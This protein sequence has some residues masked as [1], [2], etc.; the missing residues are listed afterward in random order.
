MAAG[1][2]PT[3]RVH[4]GE[5]VRVPPLDV[6]E[7]VHGPLTSNTMKNRDDDDVLKQM[8]LHEDAK[9]LVFNKPAGL[10]VQG[11]SGVT[12]Q[13]RRHARGPGANKKGEK[14]RLVHRLDRDTA[15]VLVGWR[16]PAARRNR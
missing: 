5:T 10:A 2:R 7:K 6:D 11:G 9:V 13:C 4:S 12:P 8:L 14:P 1:S 3:A 15:G 16:A